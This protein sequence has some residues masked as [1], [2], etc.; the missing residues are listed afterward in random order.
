DGVSQQLGGCLRDFRNKPFPVRARIEYYKN[1]LTVKTQ[2]LEYDYSEMEEVN[3]WST[4]TTRVPPP[5][6]FYSTTPPPTF[7]T[8][9]FPAQDFSSTTQSPDFY[10]T[11]TMSNS[12]YTT[13]TTLPP[14]T[15]LPTTSSYG[16]YTVESHDGSSALVEPVHRDYEDEMTTGWGWFGTTEQPVIDP[17]TSKPKKERRRKKQRRRR[18]RG[19]KK[20]KSIPLVWKHEQSDG[21]TCDVNLYFRFYFNGLIILDFV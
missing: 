5:S 9:A 16:L 6:E 13:S 18:G 2:L 3:E 1:V 12:D 14:Y 21:V 17:T 15:E 11:T 4:A 8:T 19:K 7:G 10:E 20:S